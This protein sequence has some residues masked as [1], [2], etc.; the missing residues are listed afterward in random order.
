M[1]SVLVTFLHVV[2]IVTEGAL[3]LKILVHRVPCVLVSDG[4]ALLDL[5]CSRA[6]DASPPLSFRHL[7]LV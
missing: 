7:S 2:L 4:E 1:V 5:T 3:L 6:Y